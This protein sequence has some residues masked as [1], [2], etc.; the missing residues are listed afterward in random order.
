M[1]SNCRLSGYELRNSS[2][3]YRDTDIQNPTEPMWRWLGLGL[4]CDA[5]MDYEPGVKDAGNID[6]E[7]GLEGC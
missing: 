1:H 3:H 5:C 7:T 6:V 4:W 2:A